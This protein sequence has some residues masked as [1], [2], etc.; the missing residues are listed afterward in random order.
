MA[1]HRNVRSS[2]L[3]R[4]EF[5]ACAAKDCESVSRGMASEQGG[6]SGKGNYRESIRSPMSSCCAACSLASGT[7]SHN[8]ARPREFCFRVT[9]NCESVSRGITERAYVAECRAGGV[10]SPSAGTPSTPT[11]TPANASPE[12]QKTVRTCQEEWRSNRAA[13]QAAKI[14]EKAYVQRCRAGEAVALPTSPAPNNPAAAAPVGTQSQPPAAPTQAPAPKQARP[15]EPTS[16]PAQAPAPT[17]AAA[18]ANPAQ[19]QSESQ[20]K[21][22]CPADLVVWANL[23]SK[24]YHFAG[25]KSYGTTKQGAYMC[26]KD[27]TAEGFRASK[28]EKRPST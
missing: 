19:F 16:A 21:A 5:G 24:I 12:T 11:E 9:E 8:S 10:A 3:P 25:H 23:T 28:T 20:A 2:A 27:A 6:Q 22:H 14:T 7:I 1:Q 17:Q 4:G 15:A 18:P 13:Y 26:E